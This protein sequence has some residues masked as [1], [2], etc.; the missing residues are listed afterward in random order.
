MCGRFALTMPSKK[1][2]A[3]FNIK[4]EEINL[5]PRYN[6]APSQQVAVVRAKGVMRSE[7][8]MM[9]WGLIPYWAKEEKVGYK[10]INARGETI[11][12]KPSFRGP[13]KKRRCLI[14]ADGFYEWAPI[15]G[16]KMKQPYFI[17][18][19]GKHLFAFAGLWEAWENP[20]TGKVIESCTIITTE[21]NTLLA[22][23]HDRMP[24]IIRPEQYGLWLAPQ[25]KGSG[26]KQLLRPYDPFKMTAY[27]VSGMCNNPK[28]DAPGC[29][30]KINS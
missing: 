21:A 9:R 4:G 29:I 30:K 2:M 11:D 8:V 10:M 17:Q 27:P 1:V 7:L 26:I 20:A 3:Q 23:I 15:P 16:E 5:I 14:P 6:I 28:Y 19:K 24:A 18:L 12:E 22:K 25:D 13:F